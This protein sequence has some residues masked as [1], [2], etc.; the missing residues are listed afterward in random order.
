MIDLFNEY[1]ECFQYFVYVFFNK[2]AF[3]SDISAGWLIL[4]I[5]LMGLAVSF[6]YG[7]FKK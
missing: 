6:L 3:T 4:T 7:R 1:L 2:L 5:S